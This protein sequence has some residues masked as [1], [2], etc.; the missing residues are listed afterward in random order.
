M[1]RDITISDDIL[2][3]AHGNKLR[4]RGG[5]MYLIHEKKKVKLKNKKKK[6]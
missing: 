4:C 5:Y 1:L 2:T 6:S 3:N